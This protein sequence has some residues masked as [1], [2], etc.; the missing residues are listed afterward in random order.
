MT[1]E[2]LAIE[3]SAARQ[4]LYTS[5]NALIQQRLNNGWYFEPIFVAGSTLT[6]A[7]TSA[8]TLLMLLDGIQLLGITSLLLDPHGLTTSLGAIAQFNSLLPVQVVEIQ[9]IF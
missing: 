3:Q 6:H 4:M 2:A 8:Q 7:P 1:D 9:C 5:I